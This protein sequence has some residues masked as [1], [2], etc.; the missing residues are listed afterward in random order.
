MKGM[1]WHV[2]TVEGLRRKKDRNGNPS[3]LR[4]N[5]RMSFWDKRQDCYSTYYTRKA[6]YVEYITR[7]HEDDRLVSFSS[8]NPKKL[9]EPA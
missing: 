5:I 4:R 3:K 8:Q 6:L 7:V 9:A 2:E 1:T